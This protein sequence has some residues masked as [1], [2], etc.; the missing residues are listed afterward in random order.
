MQPA[1]AR[2]G[3]GQGRTPALLDSGQALYASAVTLEYDSGQRRGVYSGRAR[4]WQGDTNIRAERI[5][6]DEQ[7]GDLVAEGGVQSTI[8]LASTPPLPALGG[9]ALTPASRGTIA[10]ADS[11]HYEDASRTAT[12][13]TGAHLSGP[14]GDVAADRIAIVL[15]ETGRTMERLEAYGAVTARV[16]GRD[17]RGA[18]M[19]HFAADGRYVLT[20]S[21]V[22]FTDECRVTTGRTLTFFGAAGRIIVDGNEGGRTVTKGGG[23]CGEP[24]PD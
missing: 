8:A 15:A 16:E 6:L 17:A 1:A 22:Q 14:G 3:T 23:R 18:R 10:R 5:V 12:Y 7:V 4:L 20:G 13:V 21:P 2:G 11:L 9:A 19:T 24:P